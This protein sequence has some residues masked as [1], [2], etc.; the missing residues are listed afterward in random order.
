DRDR[1]VLWVGPGREGVRRLFGHHVDGGL[2]DAPRDRDALHDVVQARLLLA[3]D[4]P[5]ARYAEHDPVAVAVR[6]D[7]VRDVDSERDQE[8]DEPVAHDEVAEEKPER[9]EEDE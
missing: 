8:P 1:G 7:A 6:V 4:G 5:G 9:A 2:W 3:R